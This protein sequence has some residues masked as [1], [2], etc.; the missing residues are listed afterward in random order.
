M[1]GDNS[2]VAVF[3]SYSHTD[4]RWLDR[5]KVHLTPLARQYDLDLWEDT[6]LRPGA[7]WREEIRLA[8]DRADA[9]ILIISADFL[10][11]EFIQNNELPP[12]LKAAEEEGTL[13]I[14]IIASPS[15]FLRR[16]DLSQFQAVNE[17]SKPLLSMQEAERE[18][19]FLNVAETLHDLASK[20]S[21]AENIF[22]QE[23][24]CHE[25]FL[26]H[27]TWNQLI[28]IGNWIFDEQKRRIIGSGVRAYLLSRHEYGEAPFVIKSRLEFSNY[29]RPKGNQ[30]G[31]NSG[32]IFGFKTEKDVNRYYNILLTGSEIL[33]ERVGFNGGLE[34]RDYEHVTEPVLLPIDSGQSYMFTVRVNVDTID[35]EVNDRSIQ[36]LKRPRGVVGRVGLRPWRSQMDCTQFVAEA[37]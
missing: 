8:V 2:R 36:S 5:L 30:L 25:D 20:P 21:K 3:V 15:L 11:S 9:A 24:V 27:A 1:K 7:K 28:K 35:I 19:V 32:L 18:N 14:P 16:Q 12:L 4:R 26:E 37:R 10:A 6:R 22:T 31:M 33:V 34:G 29:S 17:P 23:N 13:I